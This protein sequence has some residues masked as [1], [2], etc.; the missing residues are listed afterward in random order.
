MGCSKLNALSTIER[1]C[2]VLTS[3]TFG[4]GSGSRG[5]CGESADLVF[6]A[7]D[8]ASVRLAKAQNQEIAAMRL[9]SLLLCVSFDIGE[10]SQG[11]R[12][13]KLGATSRKPPGGVTGNR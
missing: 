12:P 4:L 2:V 1:P 13:S 9:R 3:R 11:T 10:W 7:M 6:P 5:S 8:K